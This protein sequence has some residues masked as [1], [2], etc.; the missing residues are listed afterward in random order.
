VSQPADS[1]RIG[2]IEAILGRDCWLDDA[3]TTV[4]P[5]DESELSRLLKQYKGQVAV[6]GSGSDQLAPESF[7]GLT[8]STSRLDGD[9]VVSIPNQTV[10][11]E[12]GIIVQTVNKTLKQ[13]NLFVPALARFKQGT[14][15]G[16][17]SSI[18]SSPRIGDSSGWI[19]SLLGLDV[20]LPMGDI[21]KTGGECIK[22]VAGYDLRH[23]FTGCRGMTGIIV[24]AIFRCRVIGSDPVNKALPE[25]NTAEVDPAIRLLFDPAHRMWAGQ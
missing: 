14:V 25:M 18:P 21:V 2:Q 6:T 10:V 13:H 23:A 17:L 3:H 20:V 1:D 19:Q 5:S 8:I 15:G 7:D 22:D 11:V 16:R 12:A 24:R 4:A 9:P